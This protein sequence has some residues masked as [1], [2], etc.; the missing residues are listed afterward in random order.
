MVQ[1]IEDNKHKETVCTSHT[2]R[3][4]CTSILTSTTQNL[5]GPAVLKPGP[6]NFLKLRAT[7]T[8]LVIFSGCRMLH[9]IHVRVVFREFGSYKIWSR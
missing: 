4:F 6:V 1:S 2:K 9:V 3:K 8:I 7:G 5:G